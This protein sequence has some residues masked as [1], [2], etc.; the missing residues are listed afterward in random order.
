M[1]I[2]I[3]FFSTVKDII[4]EIIIHN[5]IATENKINPS[6]SNIS[7]KKS[8]EWNVL[9]LKF[10]QNMIKMTIITV[11]KARMI[12]TVFFMLFLTHFKITYEQSCLSFATSIPAYIIIISRV[13]S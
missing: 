2:L 8:T 13:L 4:P 7:F 11:K 6:L 5:I 1:T 10:S 3:I 12:D 9:K